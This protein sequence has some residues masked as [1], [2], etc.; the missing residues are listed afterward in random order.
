MLNNMKIGTRLVIG[1]VTVLIL[2]TLISILSLANMSVMNSNTEDV[3]LRYYPQSVLAN[4]LTD[5]VNIVARAVRN[6]VL[7][8]VMDGMTQQEARITEAGKVTDEALAGLDQRTDSKEGRALIATIVEA[9]KGFRA[10][11]DEVVR[12]SLAQQDAEA[13]D[14][15]LN[16]MQFTQDLY[17]QAIMD[18][19]AHVTARVDEAG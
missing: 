19:V 14:Y 16:Q 1:F 3:T 9:R 7:M 13:T 8:S 2:L 6:L 15:L 5:N 11:Q 12:L 4:Q 18:L 10:D 17:M